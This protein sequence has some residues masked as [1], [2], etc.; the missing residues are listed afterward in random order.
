MI[1]WNANIFWP[2]SILLLF[3]TLLHCIFFFPF[4]CILF[5]LVFFSFYFGSLCL[6]CCHFIQN[7]HK[8][9][10]HMKDIN[11]V[12]SNISREYSRCNIIHIHSEQIIEFTPNSV[13]VASDT[14]IRSQQLLVKELIFKNILAKKRKQKEQQFIG[15]SLFDFFVSVNGA[16]YFK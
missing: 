8:H 5:L 11:F 1:N 6:Y 14:C 16:K 15:G 3:A 9:I 2:H 7:T 10:L 12:P 4:L 13:L